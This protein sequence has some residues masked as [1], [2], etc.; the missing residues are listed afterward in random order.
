MEHDSASEQPRLFMI[1]MWPTEGDGAAVKWR[2]KV[3]SLAD[4]EAYHFR[5]WDGL[6]AHLQAM[7][8]NSRDDGASTESSQGGSQ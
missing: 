6:V 2:G 8:S 5:T 4:G 1:R 7:L 3:Q